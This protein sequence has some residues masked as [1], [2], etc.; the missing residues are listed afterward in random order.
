MYIIGNALQE[1][2]RCLESP[3]MILIQKISGIM[4]QR[5]E[6]GLNT[7]LIKV[8]SHIGIEGNKI[9]D[10]LANVARDPAECQL[11]ISDGSHAFEH[12][13]WLCTLKSV[14]DADGVERRT[15][16]AAA[17]LHSC[18][19]NHVAKKFAKGLTPPGQ[20]YSFWQ[21]VKPVLHPSS[22]AFWH[23]S[24]LPFWAKVNLLKARWGQLWNKNM[25]YRQKMR[26]RAGEGV[27][28]NANCPLCGSHDGI[29]HVL[30]SC[31]HPMMKAMFIERHS[32]AA[33]MVLKLLLEGSH[34]NCYNMADIGSATRL[35]DLG[36]LDARLPDWLI[37]D[38]E[39]VCEGLSR[40]ALRPDILITTAQPP[41]PSQQNMHMHES[42]LVCRAS[43][44][45]TVWIVEVEYC[46]ATLYH[47][48][49]LEKQQQHERLPQI[50]QSKGFTVHVLPVLL[51]NTGEIFKS[52][53]SNIRLTGADADRISK[54]AS[55]LST[56]AQKSMQSIIQSRRVAEAAPQ[57]SAQSH[58]RQFEPP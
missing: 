54:L 23:N 18:I 47:D 17:N 13:K 51:G 32:I 45:K 10:K 15:W 53:L 25:A 12:R 6:Q 28:T 46:A 57:R 39:W 3:H 31:T 30:G 37:S 22:F 8:K 43:A 44:G 7:N 5:S 4:L 49:L 29:S 50:L 41:L 16:R 33:R 48:K 24:S 9:A 11:H 19:R 34:G 40:E 1:P 42:G 35:G 52:T 38:S 56:H 14:Q 58:C 21:A 55:R 27:A 2:R 20:Y 26:Y 36:A